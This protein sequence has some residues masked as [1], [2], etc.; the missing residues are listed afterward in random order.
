MLVAQQAEWEASNLQVVGSMPTEHSIFGR[1]V[2]RQGSRLFTPGMLGSIP[3]APTNVLY[4]PRFLIQGGAG[5]SVPTTAIGRFPS[6]SVM[7]DQMHYKNGREAKNGDTIVW[8]PNGG[9]GTPRV[10]FLYDAVP[11]QDY[12]NGRI[13]VPTSTDSTVNL[14]ECLHVSDALVVLQPT[15]TS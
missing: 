4:F 5:R 15:A 1:V 3:A 13:A 2:Q 8:T 6:F 11:G 9:K 7:E 10:G 12:C 14:K